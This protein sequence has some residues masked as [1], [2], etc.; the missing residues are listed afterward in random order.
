VFVIAAVALATVAACS[1]PASMSRQP[2]GHHAA[3]GG[4]SSRSTSTLLAAYGSPVRAELGRAPASGAPGVDPL[5][6][7]TCLK[8]IKS[9][10]IFAF[11]LS[12]YEAGYTNQAKLHEAAAVGVPVLAVARSVGSH[13]GLAETIADTHHHE[14]FCSMLKF[15]LRY[16][17]LRELP[18]VRAT[19]LAFGLE[20]VTATAI[21]S[22][23]G[24]APVTAIIYQNRGRIGHLS[25]QA[26]TVAVATASLGLRLTDVKVNG[27]PLNVGPD[28]H[29]AGILSTPG[30]P[31]APG[32]VMLVGG[33]RFGDP[34]PHFGLTF[35]GSVAGKVSIPPFTGCVTPS[36]ENLDPLLT[37]SV[38]GPGDYVK[39]FQGELC[40]GFHVPKQCNPEGTNTNPL[41]TVRNGRRFTASAPMTLALSNFN[42][43]S[44]FVTVTCTASAVSGAF[45][46]TEGPPRGA[47]ASVRLARIHGC[48][49]DDGSTWRVIVHGTAF[50]DGLQAMSGLTQ[51]ST[52]NLSLVLIGR[53]TGRRG[54]CRVVLSG[55]EFSTYSNGRSVLSLQPGGG[56]GDISVDKS[57]CPDVPASDTANGGGAGASATYKLVPGGTKIFSPGR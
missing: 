38:S 19:F 33:T 27:V 45:Y 25:Q 54:T 52:E 47:L 12:A 53:H 30:N 34:F 20:P 28:C 41:F 4:A 35:E 21:L 46:D 39:L 7:R 9:Q 5:A 57:N 23:Q 6:Y 32:Q 1:G 37:A 55:A 31:V 15:Q 26:P 11:P 14:Y 40:F 42:T 10:G 16:K 17:N 36:G 18:P 29:A 3:V 44:G 2:T 48:T 8:A 51:G 22:M 13:E 43:S 24:P 56:S 49:G 50:F